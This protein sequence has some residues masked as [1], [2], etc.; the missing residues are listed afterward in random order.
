[1]EDMKISK[2]EVD[3]RRYLIVNQ[4]YSGRLEEKRGSAASAYADIKK[5]LAS[6]KDSIDVDGEIVEYRT[7]AIDVE[8]PKKAPE[9]AHLE[10]HTTF[11]ITFTAKPKVTIKSLM[12][13]IVAKKLPWL[14]REC[15]GVFCAY[16]I[17]CDAVRLA[18][19]IFQ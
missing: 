12:K 4:Y 16:K 17:T 10:K 13:R 9:R 8:D 1:M 19:D 14:T 15:V 3:E 11:E 7:S 5:A 2:I 18:N 6:V